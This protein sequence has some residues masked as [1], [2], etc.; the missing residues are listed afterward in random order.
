[1]PKENSALETSTP[2]LQ[3]SKRVLVSISWTARQNVRDSH[4]AFLVHTGTSL[5]QEWSTSAACV[6]L[7]SP[8]I[9]A[10]DPSHRA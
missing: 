5:R 1:M 3:D 6:K 8:H 10:S 9:F 7:G 4:R 2:T